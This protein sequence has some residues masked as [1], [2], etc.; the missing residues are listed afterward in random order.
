MQVTFIQNPR[1]SRLKMPGCPT[2]KQQLFNSMIFSFSIPG[3]ESGG[4]RWVPNRL[5]RPN[6]GKPQGPRGAGPQPKAF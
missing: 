3:L 6:F 1:I 4:D 5:N 2:G